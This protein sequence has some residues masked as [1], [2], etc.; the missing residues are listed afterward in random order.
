MVCID[1]KMRLK[2]LLGFYYGKLLF[3]A[4]SKL[5]RNGMSCFS[6]LCTPLSLDSVKPLQSIPFAASLL[7][8][9]PISKGSALYDTCER[10]RVNGMLNR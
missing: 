3:A 4:N 1:L 9:Y 10:G 5:F 2:F 6:V 8:T 7:F